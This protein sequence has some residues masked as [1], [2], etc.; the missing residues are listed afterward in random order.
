MQ[1]LIIMFKLEASLATYQTSQLTFTCSKSPIETVNFF[2]EV[3]PF[4]ASSG[5]DHFSIYLN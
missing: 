1:I 5:F 4:A 3:N 2:V